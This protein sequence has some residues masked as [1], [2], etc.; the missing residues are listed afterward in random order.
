VLTETYIIE[1]AKSL[2]VVIPVEDMEIVCLMLND[3]SEKMV[4]VLA[5]IN[6]RDAPPELFT[7]TQL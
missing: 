5:F 7:A 2:G 4:P 6:G 1:L 3:L